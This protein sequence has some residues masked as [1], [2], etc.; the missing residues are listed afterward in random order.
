MNINETEIILHECRELMIRRISSSMSK[1]MN[2]AEDTLFDMASK[3]KGTAKASQYFDAVR[4][5]RIKK[6]EMLIRFEKR[7]DTLFKHSL[8]NSIANANHTEVTLSKV[9]HSSFVKAAK[10][11]EG[12]MLEAAVSKVKVD[13]KY[14]LLNLDK[15]ISGLLEDVEIDHIDNPMQP[16]TVF[17]AFWESCRD[18]KMKTELRLVL[19]NLFEKYV[20]LD[21]KYLYEDLNTYLSEKNIE[22]ETE[23][24]SQ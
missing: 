7:F 4:I 13:C 3:E 21:L 10:S 1:M 15:K 12:E 19:V 20:A 6:D 22:L 11:A 8:W 17:E 2:E 16:E 14:A 9:G 24:K 23:Q 18:V 5:I